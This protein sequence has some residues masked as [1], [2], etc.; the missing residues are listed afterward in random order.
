MQRILPKDGS[1][2]EMAPASLGLEFLFTPL[3]NP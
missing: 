3:R 1:G 2:A